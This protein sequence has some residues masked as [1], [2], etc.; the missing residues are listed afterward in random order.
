[1]IFTSG[2]T[3]WVAV[4]TTLSIPKGRALFVADPDCVAPEILES[5]SSWQST[6]Y[7]RAPDGEIVAIN[8]TQDARPQIPLLMPSGGTPIP[9][10]PIELARERK[11]NHLARVHQW[12]RRGVRFI[13][14]HRVYIG[15]RVEL[16]IGVQVWP[17]VVLRGHCTISAGVE[18][19]AGCVLR[20]TSVAEGSIIKAHT[21]AEQA[22]I[23]PHC[24]VGPMAH[25]RA[26]TV[27]HDTVK[28]GNFVETKKAVLHAG[29]KASHLTYLGDAEVGPAA[30]IGAGTITCNYDGYNK[31]KTVIRAGAFVGSNSSLV[32]PVVVGE[33]AII[34]A[35][36]V[37]TRDVPQDAIAIERNTQN[38][39][40][41]RAP[42]LRSKL[43]KMK[44]ARKWE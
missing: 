4:S 25:L 7:L 1:M 31:H 3:G 42:R 32:A 16:A 12:M 39:L 43:S 9:V 29:A 40:E 18:L 36:S 34:G 30:N 8:D 21:V 24:Q 23:G 44:E 37:I 10:D 19:Q 28:V 5:I 35:G 20:D 6:A 26:G 22:H 13:D 2:P 14:P 11:E 33:G 15:P 27:L 41:G 38:N 17:D